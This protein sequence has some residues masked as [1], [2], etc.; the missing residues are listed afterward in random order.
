MMIYQSFLLLLLFI[1]NAS[2]FDNDYINQKVKMLHLYANEICSYRGSPTPFEANVFKCD[3]IAG[4]TTVKSSKTFMGEPVQCSYK[5]KKRSCALFLA[6]FLPLGFDYL[7]I[8]QYLAFSFI[9]TIETGI[10]I[11]FLISFY[12]VSRNDEEKKSSTE[13]NKSETGLEKLALISW[14]MNIFFFL[15]WFVDIL[16]MAFGIIKDGK[17]EEVYNDL[18]LLLRAF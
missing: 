11:F 5:Q 13:Q 7:Y 2:C 14:M 16:L 3:C 12:M 9:I 18:N 15:Y 6:L 8:E 10:F 17:G 1:H 4:Y